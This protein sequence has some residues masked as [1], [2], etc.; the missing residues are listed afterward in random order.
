M[1]EELSPKE[2][3]KLEAQVEAMGHKYQ[4]DIADDLVAMKVFDEIERLRN[5]RATGG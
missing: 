2:V 3:A 5:Q 1:T 4:G